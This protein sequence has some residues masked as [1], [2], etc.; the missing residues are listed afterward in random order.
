MS[1]SSLGYVR[2]E[3]TDIARWR[4]FG[5][6]SIGLMASDGPEGTLY[7]RSDERPFRFLVHPGSQDR[8][9]AA[10]LEMCNER[11]FHAALERL[12]KAGV[13]IT[14]G[15]EAEAR[16]RCVD[17]FASCK[18][19]SGNSLELYFGRVLESSAFVSAAGV[20]GF[21]GGDL[22]MGHVVLPA[23]KL[24]ETRA[25]YKEHL[26][27]DDTDE[28]RVPLSPD[29][30]G[31]ELKIYFMHCTNRRHHTV[32]LIPMPAPSGLVHTMLEARAVDDV[33]RAYDR[34]VAASHRISASL[35][36][37]SNDLM[38]S[39]YVQ[40]PAGFDLE[41]GCDGLTPDWSTWVPTRN[42]APSLWGHQWA[43]PPQG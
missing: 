4:A 30:N 17:A 3:T 42:L 37:H 10:G 29:P 12:A 38:F 24:E 15:S 23:M 21:V 13:E 1:V 11:S 41:V 20:S 19:P 27:F 33:G 18:D 22:G 35:G 32:A 2:L 25:F 14:R 39:F 36:R 43:R 40:T 8:F 28:I 26:D 6:E 7:L 9:L 16:T 31:P 34:C 5:S